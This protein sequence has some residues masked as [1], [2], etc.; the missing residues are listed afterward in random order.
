MSI[1][2]LAGCTFLVENCGS[3][4]SSLARNKMLDILS[5]FLYCAAKLV[6]HSDG[7]SVSSNGMFG[8]RNQ[9]RPRSIFVKI[10]YGISMRRHKASTRSMDYT[11]STNSH[12]GRLHL[13]MIVLDL[14]SYYHVKESNLSYYLYF[15]SPAPRLFKLVHANISAAVKSNGFHICCPRIIG[16][17]WLDLEVCVS[18]LLLLLSV[19]C[20]PRGF[21]CW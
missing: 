13:C 1:S 20:A 14:C 6:T 15:A 3:N 4:D 19:R 12:K 10:Y 17:D 2:L 9:N 5:S 8:L 7:I 16:P 21:K 18:L 11:A